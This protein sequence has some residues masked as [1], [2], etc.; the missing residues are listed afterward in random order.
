LWEI[1]GHQA[2]L[3][4]FQLFGPF[5]NLT[6]IAAS[7]WDSVL[8]PVRPPVSPPGHVSLSASAFSSL[9]DSGFDCRFRRDP[10]VVTGLKA[11]LSRTISTK[12]DDALEEWQVKAN[13]ILHEHAES[14]EGRAR[15]ARAK[16]KNRIG[17]S[18]NIVKGGE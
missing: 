15:R 9:L 4:N 13:T 12:L 14:A 8:S 10:P 2:K 3:A 16:R 5:T 6:Q 11:W 17:H 7:R 1:V 18:T